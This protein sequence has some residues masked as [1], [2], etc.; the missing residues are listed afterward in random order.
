MSAKPREAGDLR[1]SQLIFSYGVGAVVALPNFSAM[2]LGLEHWLQAEQRG[3]RIPEQRLL[4]AVRERLGPQVQALLEGPRMPDDAGGGAS[5]LRASGPLVGVGVAA[6]PR[7]FVCP[8][9]RKLAPLEAG[10][11]K[12]Y[13]GR[14]PD[15]LRYRCEFCEKARA[16]RPQVVPA[17]FLV[18]CPRGHI[19]DFPWQFYVHGGPSSCTG[20]LALLETSPSGRARDVLLECRGCGARRPMAQAFEQKEEDAP[21]LPACRGR[22]LHLL[23][24][25]EEACAA[26]LSATLMGASNLWFPVTVSA[27]ALPVEGEALDQ[28]VARLWEGGLGIATKEALPMLLKMDAFKA[29]SG[30]GLDAVWSAMER[31]RAKDAGEATPGVTDLKRPEWEIFLEGETGADRD[32]EVQEA[33]VPRSLSSGIER[34]LI[35]SRLREVRAL[36][37]FTRLQPPASQEEREGT[38]LAIAPLSASRPEWVPASEVRGEGLLLVWSEKQVRTWESQHAAGM[39]DRQM[40]AA[41]TAWRRDRGL[42]PP[43]ASYP[44]LRF[45]LLHSFAHALIQQ[46]AIECGYSAASLRER[47]YVRGAEEPGGPM[48][49]VLLYTAAPDSEG[50]LGGLARLGQPAELE[51][52]VGAMLERLRRCSS[53]PLC[54]EHAPREDGLT[55]HGAACHAC[56]FVSETSCE[57]GNRY[58]DRSV[59][60]PTLASASHA[61]LGAPA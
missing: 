37:G 40:L 50:T 46:F 8:R 52:H 42:T 60:V 38:E 29:L 26:P 25:E 45:V 61:F 56:L 23:D 51:H 15:Q 47:L 27:L 34:V 12:L 4:A 44:G 54:A 31:R 35:V 58:L 43:S 7:W 9:C 32:F 17:R 19:D 28:E 2:V 53:D 10:S 55:I 57:V 14:S 36:T 21:I 48:A 39:L 16:A 24:Q 59:L 6:F 33:P 49:G 18:A 41:H 11:F 22:R 1:P 3:R 30:H 13:P 5:P 20:E